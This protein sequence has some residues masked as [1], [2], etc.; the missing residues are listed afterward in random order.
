[1]QLCDGHPDCGQAED[2]A[3]SE[4]ECGPGALRCQLGGGCVAGRARCDGQY[5]CADRSD[6]WGC[7]EL[8]NNTLTVRSVDTA[9]FW[10]LMQ[11]ANFSQFCG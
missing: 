5:Q 8:L 1:M 2:E 11:C 4:C 3:A 9:V 7:L 10:T 6:E